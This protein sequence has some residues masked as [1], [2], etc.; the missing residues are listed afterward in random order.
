MKNYLRN[1]KNLTKKELRSIIDNPATYVITIVFLLIWEYIFF[2]NVFVIGE[3]SLTLLFDFFPWISLLLI[4]AITMGSISKEKD[5]GTL[6]LVLTHPIRSI[7]LVVSKFLGTLIYAFTVILFTLP[8]A[9]YFNKYGPLDWGIYTGQLLG[10]FFISAALISLGIFISSLFSS[11]IA[12][13]LVT[14]FSG[15]AFVVLGTELVTISLPPIVGNYVEKLSLANHYQSMIRGVIS[16]PDLV[17]FLIFTLLF[18]FLANLQVLK[19]SSNELNKKYLIMQWGAS[20]VA[21]SLI[22]TEA[23]SIFPMRI[24]ITQNKIYTLSSTTHEILSKATSP[25]T[26]TLY[27][28]ENLPTQYAPVIRETKYILQDYKNAAKDKILLEYKDPTKSAE[29]EQEVLQFGIQ[30][31]Q[32]NIIGQ[33]EL[34]AKT[35]YLGVLISYGGK[36]EVISFVQGTADLEYELTSLINKLVNSDKKTVGFLSGHGEKSVY[37]DYGYL[38]S[39]LSK[40][41]NVKPFYLSEESNVID[42][43]ID[44]LVLA[45]PTERIDEG[46]RNALRDFF[47]RGKSIVMFVDNILVNS[48]FTSGSIDHGLQNFL[49]EYGINLKGDVVYDLK[50]HEL[51]NIQSE[52]NSFALPYEFW[53]RS[54]VSPLSQIDNIKTS[55]ISLPWPSSITFDGDKAKSLGYSIKPLLITS[56][57]AGV[58]SDDFVVTPEQDLPAENLGKITVA[59]SMEPTDPTASDKGKLVLISDSEFLV[60]MFLERVPT[61]LAFGLD[62][63]SWISSEKSL[64]D[65]QVKVNSASRFAFIDADQSATIKYFIYGLSA[66][67]P[68]LVG[69]FRYMRRR[70]LRTKTYN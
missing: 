52:T 33:D 15:F 43:T 23:V 12:S 2:R 9:F 11:Q 22:L 34:Q 35:G 47:N 36:N 53:I 19:Q 42:E 21:V 58:K 1:I 16:I 25:I 51:L 41:F 26:L 61:N 69:F 40:L 55:T 46:T 49:E 6:E 38:N 50:F 68:V 30:R 17:F 27:A 59:I 18:L 60:N 54:S 67:I 32:F 37:T 7:E 29:S 62:L 44:V 65:I 56:D 4:P 14:V 31:A 24:D 13:L 10:A 64:A 8:V 28:S 57:F 63:F 39:E 20:L 5:D 70:I 66:L 48:S 45:G 3:S